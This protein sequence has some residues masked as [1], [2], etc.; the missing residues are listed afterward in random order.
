MLKNSIFMQKKKKAL[1]LFNLETADNADA[2]TNQFSITF[3]S[4]ILQPVL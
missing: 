4:A 3:L 2:Y 1:K